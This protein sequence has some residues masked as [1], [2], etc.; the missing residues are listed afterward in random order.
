MS[1]PKKRPQIAAS[2]AVF[3]DGKVLIARRGKPP[4]LWSLPGGRVEM[5]ETLEAA[6]A[7]EV[8]EET[9][10]VCEIADFAG[11]REMMLRDEGGNLYAHFVIAA[12]AAR[13]KS[14][15]A[16]PGPEASEVVW[17]NPDS[18]AGFET[19]PGLVEIIA[20]AREILGA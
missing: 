6:A 10:V 18:V 11:H 2:A 1:D 9:G 13:W 16:K 20:R 19:T 5:G 7:R 4:H 17:V 14:G 3:R 8:L 15:E 12:F